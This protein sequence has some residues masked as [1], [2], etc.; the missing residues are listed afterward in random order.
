MLND[1]FRTR[2]V[3]DWVEALNTAGVPAGPVYNVQQMFEDPQVQHLKTWKEVTSKEGIRKK[4]ITQPCVLN[5]T[6]AD[7]VTIAPSC[8]EHTEEVLREAGYGAE[9]IAGFRERGVV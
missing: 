5:R 4:L 8:G 6:P 1:I 2:T 9:E 3:N 7:I